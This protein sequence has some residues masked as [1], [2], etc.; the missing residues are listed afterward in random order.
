MKKISLSYMFTA[1]LIVASCGTTN[2]IEISSPEESGLN[3]MKITDENSNTVAGSVFSYGL[4]PSSGNMLGRCT[5][6][7][8]TWSVGRFLAMSPNGNELA[9]ISKI[10][11]Q[12]NIMVRKT[13]AQAASTQRT[14]RA[15]ED[16]SWGCDDKLYFADAPSSGTSQISTMDS[17]V[18]TIMRQLTNNNKD[19]N[20]VLSADGE[21]LYFT[22]L[23]QS[24][25]FI[26]S[27][28]IG[29]G[30]LTACCKGFNPWPVSENEFLCVRNSNGVNSFMRA[31]S[32]SEIW[33]V[34][35]KEGKETLI[36]SDK[37]RGFTNPVLS[38]DGQWILCQGNS[39][40]A[41]KKSN[42]DIYVI[43][44]DGSQFI[45]LTYHPADDCCPVW[46]KDGEYIYF[47]SSRANKEKAFNIWK[48]KF[49][50]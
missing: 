48:M 29:T 12:W 30:A 18:G 37:K 24:G 42:L 36:Y 22:R 41:S 44:M 2:Y 46:S 20:P 34:N 28:E 27:Y 47:I 14:F 32:T 15:V 43:K 13:G 21:I 50:L 23:D 35:Y 19:F 49:T 4:R 25:P 1:A 31:N 8:A 3:L 5:D 39:K 9:Y 45:Q 6:E 40:S 16:F 7:N 38:P 17:H 11:N 33:L 26:W 10:N